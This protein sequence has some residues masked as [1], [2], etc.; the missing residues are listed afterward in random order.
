MTLPV[1]DLERSV[2]FYRAALVA[3]MGWVEV[4]VEGAPT[5][6]PDGAEDVSLVAGGPLQ[7]TIHLA[8]AATDFAQVRDS[9]GRA[10]PPA[11]ATTAL[12][13][14]ERS[15]RRA[16]TA[17]SSSIPTA[18]TSR[19]SGTRRRSGVPTS[20]AETGSRQRG[21]LNGGNMTD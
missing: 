2:A 5:F 20:P 16:T 3:G 21:S 7:P 4:E 14:R 19:R 8:F 6:G 18:T 12:Q 9:T 1:G 13:G 10:S 11:A 17:P 15:T